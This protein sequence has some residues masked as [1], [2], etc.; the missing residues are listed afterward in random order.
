[1]D[2]ILEAST[3]DKSRQLLV[4]SA[5]AFVKGGQV[6]KTP[7]TKEFI[8]HCAILMC[9]LVDAF[10]TPKAKHLY[11]DLAQSIWAA[12]ETFAD[13]GTTKAIA[14]ITA[15]LCYTLEM[16]HILHQPLSRQNMPKEKKAR[17]RKERADFQ[18]KVFIKKK[19]FDDKATEKESIED[20]VIHALNTTKEND[21]NEN[22]SNEL[23]TVKTGQFKGAI[24]DTPPK[25]VAVRLKD[26]EGFDDSVSLPLS[27]SIMTESPSIYFH[28]EYDHDDKIENAEPLNEYLELGS[29][30]ASRQDPDDEKKYLKI[31]GRQREDSNFVSA[32]IEDIVSSKND[33]SNRARSEQSLNRSVYS[34]VK[35]FMGGSK[36]RYEEEEYDKDHNMDVDS[37]ATDLNTSS[38]NDSL[39]SFLKNDEINVGHSILNSSV[40]QHGDSITKETINASHKYYKVMEE[41]THMRRLATLQSLLNSPHLTTNVE[42]NHKEWFSAAAAAAGAGNE[43]GQDIIKQYVSRLKTNSRSRTE[44]KTK[45]D[46]KKTRQKIFGFIPTRT[47][48][49]MLIICF[50]VFMSLVWFSLGVYG[51]YTLL[52]PQEKTVPISQEPPQ[53][54]VRV[55]REVV[56]RTESAEKTD[57]LTHAIED[58]ASTEHFKEQATLQQ[59]M[60][61]YMKTLS[62]INVEITMDVKSDVEEQN[63]GFEFEG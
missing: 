54:F 7:E 59:I 20:V 18:K 37:C 28:G 13:P 55:V 56:V 17:Q 6:L 21:Q 26:Y 42:Q 60:D 61:S 40:L 51:L 2:D 57:I 34:K 58:L 31:S 14:Q 4:E 33:L 50:F 49:I 48:V 11:H 38:G 3:T 10:S 47:T 9:R 24:Q 25:N 39:N 32:D 5:A 44:A 15:N 19:V 43:L 16:E 36:V 29:I 8:D 30:S 1:M 62:E 12:I 63:E 27:S 22:G 53:I 45:T 46:E 41:T 35:K 23:S 52:Q